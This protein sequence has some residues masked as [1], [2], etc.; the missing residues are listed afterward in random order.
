MDGIGDDPV[1]S[2]RDASVSTDDMLMLRSATATGSSSA[3]AIK[4]WAF[5]R[6]Y[7]K[8]DINSTV[9]IC[10]HSPAILYISASTARHLS[11][12]RNF[13]FYAPK[14][15]TQMQSSKQ[16]LMKIGGG[17]ASSI[18]ECSITTSAWWTS[19]SRA[20]TIRPSGIPGLVLDKV[21]WE[22][23]RESSQDE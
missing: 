8:H 14:L 1:W 17:A 15:H 3:P 18:R 13:S 12:D 22:G 19:A 11:M 10:R 9:P 20:T 16:A 23:L 21:G 4:S 2:R 6:R 7:G 5:S